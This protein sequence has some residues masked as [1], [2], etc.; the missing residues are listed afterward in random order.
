MSIS[1]CA[2][3]MLWQ[4]DHG[5]SRTISLEVEAISKGLYSPCDKDVE[6]TYI[7]YKVA[8][9]P[10]NGNLEYPPFE[11]GFIV[12]SNN[13]ALKRALADIERKKYFTISHVEIGKTNIS[14]S[15]DA[16][17]YYNL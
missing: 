10:A 11:D 2:T 12:V 13:H 4:V 9:V 16:T 14:N 17:R 1:G 3:A 7:D 8:K 6:S 15:N 5:T